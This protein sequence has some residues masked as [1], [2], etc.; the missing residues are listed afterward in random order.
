MTTADQNSLRVIAEPTQANPAAAAPLD[1]F[2]PNSLRLDQTFVEGGGVKKL[3]TTV[4]IRKPSQQD[5][6]RV[7]PDPAWQLTAAAI[8][9]KEDRE[10][11][12]L[13]PEMANECVSEFV[14]IQLFTAI[15]RQKVIFLWPIR[16]PGSDGKILEWHRSAAEAAEHAMKRWVRVKANMSLGAY[17]PFEA[18]STIPDPEWPDVSFAE[19]LRIGFR[20]RLVDALDHQVLKRLRGE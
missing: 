11:F 5:F 6:I 4:P 13:R 2:D 7:H 16:L 15:N 1:P 10:W 8:E 18:Q 20:D 3:L 17:E 12:L 9:L 14:P 19:L